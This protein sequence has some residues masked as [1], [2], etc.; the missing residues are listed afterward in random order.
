MCSGFV[1]PVSGELPPAQMRLC[2]SSTSSGVGS[3][4]GSRL[5]S[6]LHRYFGCWLGL[7]RRKSFQPGLDISVLSLRELQVSATVVDLGVPCSR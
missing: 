2:R 6:S 4:R 1:L 7:Q 5:P 3:H